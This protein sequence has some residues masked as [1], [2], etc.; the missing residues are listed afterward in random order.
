MISGMIV[1]PLFHRRI[2][3]SAMSAPPSSPQPIPRFAIAWVQRTT[4]GVF[5]GPALFRQFVRFLAAV[6]FFHLL[7]AAAGPIQFNQPRDTPGPFGLWDSSVSVRSDIGHRDNVMLAATNQQAS[8][9]LGFGADLFVFRLPVDGTSFNLLFTADDRRYLN[10]AEGSTNEPGAFKEQTFLTHA[11]LKKPLSNGWSVSLAALHLYADQVFD[12]SDL[13]VG[14][15]SVQAQGHRLSL[16]PGV[17]RDF[18]PGVWT[19]LTLQLARQFYHTPVSSYWEVGPKMTLGWSYQTNSSV[20]VSLQALRR[21]FDDRF[22]MSAFGDPYP[23][24]SLSTDDLKV[25][26]AWKQTWLQ[27][28]RLVS[29]VKLFHTRRVDNGE[30]WFD[31]DRMGV[32]ASLKYETK[33]FQIRG[34]ARWT[35]YDYALERASPLDP[36][37]RTRSDLELE[38]RV[39]YHFHPHW[40]AYFAYEYEQTRSNVVLDAYRMNTVFAG[41]EFEF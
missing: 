17:R 10:P 6:L 36:E 28:K 29:T 32:S 31:V 39:E 25:E 7:P 26:L 14:I 2:V 20:E 40:M 15:G 27:P 9:F 13:E 5:T 3:P 22:Q 30:G 4:R 11:S 16:T 34:T 37:L 35:E 18:G 1:G 21:P 41:V 24:L 23:S 8:A 33:K 19:E 12:A 38:G